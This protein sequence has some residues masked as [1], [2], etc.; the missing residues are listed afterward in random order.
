MILSC[1]RCA[2]NTGAGAEFQN[3]VYG[4]GN[5]VHNECAKSG[6]GPVQY[7]CT[8]CKTERPAKGN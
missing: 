8:I 5:R 4:S 3:K 6:T 2:D 1:F 7:R